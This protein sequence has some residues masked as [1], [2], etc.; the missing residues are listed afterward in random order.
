MTETPILYW[1]RRDMRLADNPALCA[2]AAQGLV[3]PVFIVD[4][5]VE[6]LG[7]A[8]KWR[9]GLGAEAFGDA[10]RAAGSGLVIRRGEALETL[11][12][13]VAETGARAVHWN[14]LYDPAARAR[15]EG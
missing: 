11:R 12:A 10:L 4:E 1:V 8:P 13:L 2:A 15:D 7:A 5:V 6:T 9:L 14:R 3:M